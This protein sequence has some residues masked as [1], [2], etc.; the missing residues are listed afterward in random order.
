MN[1]FTFPLFD[2]AAASLLKS[3]NNKEVDNMVD[4]T[5]YAVIDLE[6]NGVNE[7]KDD[8]LSISLYRPDTHQQIEILEGNIKRTKDE[9]DLLKSPGIINPYDLL[10]EKI[11]IKEEKRRERSQYIQLD[12]SKWLA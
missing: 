11:K 7:K 2:S 9:E 5:K 3:S 8:L 4:K 10:Q 6:T 12:C 1:L